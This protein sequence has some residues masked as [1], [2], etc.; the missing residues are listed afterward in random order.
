M[1]YYYKHY[2]GSDYDLFG[3]FDE[4]V[5]YTIKRYEGPFRTERECVEHA[6][7]QRLQYFEVLELP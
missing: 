3:P 2:E 5:E 7:S 6:A 1:S 4:K